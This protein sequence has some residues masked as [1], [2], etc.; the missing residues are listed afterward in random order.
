[1]DKYG[2]DVAESL[3]VNDLNL[4]GLCLNSIGEWRAAV[5]AY[6]KAVGLQKQ[7]GG[8]KEGGGKPIKELLVNRAQA[9][10]DGGAAEEVS[11]FPV[12]YL[13]QIHK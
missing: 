1:L 5:R 11:E 2:R 9:K 12:Q 8:M 4:M 10:R 13:I 6:T 7:Q 3:D